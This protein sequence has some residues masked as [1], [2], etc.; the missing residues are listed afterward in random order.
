MDIKNLPFDW[1]I[2]NHDVSDQLSE[3]EREHAWTHVRLKSKKKGDGARTAAVREIGQSKMNNQDEMSQAF[4]ESYMND[5]VY[6]SS[7]P[8]DDVIEWD[9]YE[10][11]YLD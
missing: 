10:G 2:E 9:D 7:D 11:D 6:S 5:S 3:I 4:I 1:E 8:L